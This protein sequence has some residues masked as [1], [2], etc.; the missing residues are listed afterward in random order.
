M[1]FGRGLIRRDRNKCISNYWATGD[2]TKAESLSGT[3]QKLSQNWQVVTSR[4]Y[5]QN[6]PSLLTLRWSRYEHGT[7]FFL[8]HLTISGLL[9]LY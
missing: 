2:H 1:T 6:K 8:T 4:L 7:G 3:K 9:Q 5:L